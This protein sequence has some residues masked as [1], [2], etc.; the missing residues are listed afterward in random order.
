M[1]VDVQ[2]RRR[3]IAQLSQGVYDALVIGGGINGAV[4]AAS[5]SCKGAK[6]ALI[7]QRDFA[8]FT[9]QHSSN[10]VWGG[11]KYLETYEFRLVW[12]LC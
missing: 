1:L 11:I 2:L 12:E 10:L 9:S 7:E 4:A 3:N 5:L 8:G 6:V